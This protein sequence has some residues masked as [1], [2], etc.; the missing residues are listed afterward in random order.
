MFQPLNAD[1]SRTY[2]GEYVLAPRR[3]GRVTSPP[4]EALRR[5]RGLVDA[6]HRRCLCP[7]HVGANRCPIQNRDIRILTRTFRLCPGACHPSI[8]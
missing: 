1:Q 7:C 2:I 5:H 4:V 8:G 6:V 3:A